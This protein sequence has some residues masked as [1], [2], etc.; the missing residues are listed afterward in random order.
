MQSPPEQSRNGQGDVRTSSGVPAPASLEQAQRAVRK[1]RP[2]GVRSRL[3]PEERKNLLDALRASAPR[4]RACDL[5]GIPY[6]TLESWLYVAQ[7]KNP[8]QPATPWHKALLK[9]VLKAEAQP[10]VMLV[11]NV[12]AASKAHPE[13]A[14]RY[15]QMRYSGEFGPGAAAEPAPAPSLPQ[16]YIIVPPER[17]TEFARAISTPPPQIDATTGRPINPLA[18]FRHEE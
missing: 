14:V 15:L 10:V 18:G 7:G 17:L 9:D 16:K 3:S 8:R 5:A 12:T 11:G 13:A 2:Q 1:R 6:K 4:R